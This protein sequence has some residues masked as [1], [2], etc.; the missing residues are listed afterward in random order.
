MKNYLVAILLSILLFSG[1]SLDFLRDFGSAVGQATAAIITYRPD[2]PKY[3]DTN[4]RNPFSNNKPRNENENSLGFYSDDVMF[5]TEMELDASI[6]NYN[7]PLSSAV[8]ICREE[9]DSIIIY[10]KIVRYP[11]SF[12]GT[13]DNYD[14]Y[15]RRIAF[16][17]YPED[18]G[19][20]DMIHISGSRIIIKDQN[21]VSYSANSAVFVFNE[22]L[23]SGN[24]HSGAFSV[25]YNDLD[26]NE[27]SLE[28][29]R[30]K[31]YDTIIES[32]STSLFERWADFSR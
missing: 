7:A 4:P 21:D 17:I 18:I 20:D 32:Y 31:L 14:S 6:Y 26:G 24:Y 8:M 28:S 1:C 22:S 12:Y 19:E 16:F 9:K 27:C 3:M 15:F 2:D 30:F 5:I 23:S 13:L 29:G 11:D 10:S 25:A